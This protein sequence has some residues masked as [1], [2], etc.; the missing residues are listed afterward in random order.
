[1]FRM[2]YLITIFLIILSYSVFSQERTIDK[3]H[4]FEEKSL[5]SDLSL[6]KSIF[7]FK[8]NEVRIILN[9]NRMLK[10]SNLKA[11]FYIL[12]AN[13]YKEHF[14]YDSAISLYNNALNYSLAETKSK[15]AQR[16]AVIAYLSIAKI[17]HQL[18]D[19]VNF[20]KNIERAITLS[21]QYK[22][23]DLKAEAYLYYT[24]FHIYKN[25]NQIQSYLNYSTEYFGRM[26]IYSELR[27]CYLLQNIL[28]QSKK[29]YAK[30]KI[31]IDK[32]FDIT[33][34][35]SLLA[36]LFYN[37]ALLSENQNLPF[38][39]YEEDYLKALELS[40][41]YNIHETA[42]KVSFKLLKIYKKQNNFKQTFEIQ[43]IYKAM[44]DSLS[45]ISSQKKIFLANIQNEISIKE[46]TITDLESKEI[47]NKIKLK[48]YERNR[49]LLN[50][51]IIFFSISLIIALYYFI[52]TQNYNKKIIKKNKELEKSNEKLQKT[53]LELEEVGKNK[54]RFFS[55][56]AHD[57][58][59]PFNSVLGLSE[60]IS[61]SM[62]ELEKEDIL[63]FNQLIYT[64]SKSLYNL[65]ENLL[66][67][68][69]TQI[70]QL[71]FQPELFDLY[72]IVQKELAVL[73]MIAANKN[74]TIQAEIEK[75]T[76]AYFDREMIATV[77]RNITNNA[78]KFTKTNG[79]IK[80]NA[81]NKQSTI[82]VSIEDNGIGISAENI[83]KLFN[84]EK[85][86]TT[87]GTNGEKGTGLGLAICREFVIINGGNIEVTSEV[88]KR[89]TFTFSIPC[90]KKG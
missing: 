65:L 78:I 63:K 10:P 43:L 66:D 45:K 74:I 59:S 18:N 73:K 79:N 52:L 36:N 17:D 24:K 54:D 39:S 32:S 1:V 5:N 82:I 11:V 47:E 75:N 30:A 86:F 90:T 25:T 77:V 72:E 87:N 7:N 46:N 13:I 81:Q 56:I 55:I 48:N 29:E 4:Y 51:L 28:F 58:R 31:Y 21:E 44:K 3:V 16:L 23:D 33:Q 40:R 70:G 88:G 15:K 27:A 68:S 80:I 83:K 60:Y 89:S 14:N 64:S 34:N 41:K 61:D 42:K 37:K 62:E 49:E 9:T 8:P 26:Q 67:W 85:E 22:F 50:L 76:F 53:K 20:N 84:A 2:R 57:L 35:D 12:S 19:S 38:E 6:L 71:K 69:K